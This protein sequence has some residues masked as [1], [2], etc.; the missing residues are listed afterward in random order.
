MGRDI[1]NGAFGFLIAAEGSSSN[2][3]PVNVHLSATWHL[4]ELV[5]LQGMT[6]QESGETMLL[7]P[8]AACC[9][10]ST[11]QSRFLVSHFDL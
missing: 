8:G 2:R 4:W 1:F 9:T 10:L 3:G 6:C 11:Y 5:E 7:S